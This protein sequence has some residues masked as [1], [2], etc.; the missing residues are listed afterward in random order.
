MDNDKGCRM[1][2]L[3]VFMDV[4]SKPALVVGGGEV[5]SRKVDLLLSVN[6]NVTV[7]SPTLNTTLQRYADSGRINIIF[8][9]YDVSYLSDYLMVWV[10]T[11][12]SILNQQIWQ[13]C[14][15]R[16]L[17]V[18]VADQPHLCAFITPS[19]IDRSPLQIA[20]SSAGTS[21]VLIRYIR[22]K[23]EALLPISLGLLADFSGRQR[24]TV[25]QRFSCGTERRRFW[26]RFF[27]SDA[28]ALT[29][30]SA[31][32]QAEF[33][34]QL[35]ANITTAQGDI[36]LLHMPVDSELLTLKALRLMQQSD[37]IVYGDDIAADFIDLCRRDAE[38][39]PCEYK[40]QAEIAIARRAQGERVCLLVAGDEAFNSLAAIPDVQVLSVSPCAM[41]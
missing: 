1:Q 17:L 5:A 22:E 19:I 11:D 23:L 21:P 13:D 24:E 20:I 37:V 2:Y 31:Q 26:E 4:N 32:L 29:K 10:T 27:S 8:A 14:Q 28:L 35:S 25:K 7:L 40:Q 16:Q 6:A 18:N 9:C 36:Y 33:D 30:D 15:S 3:P 38:R 39:R 41:A 34:R 12:N